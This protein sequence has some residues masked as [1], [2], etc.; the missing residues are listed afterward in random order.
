MTKL[1]IQIPCYNEAETL[2]ITLSALPREIPG[3]SCVEWLVIDDGSTDKTLAVAKDFGVDRIVRLNHNQG[4]AKAFMAGIEACLIAGADII[5]NTDAD[6]QY[7]ADDIPKLIAPILL[8]R[9]EIVIGTRPIYKIKHFS[10]TKKV[11]QKL[12][13]WVVRLASNTNIPDAPSGFR[14]ISRAAALQLNVFNEYTYTL[15]TIIQAGQKGIPMTAV[16]IRTNKYLRPSR[17]VK[18][19][20]TYIQR[21]LFTILRIFMTYQPLKFFTILGSIPFSLGTLLGI[22]W[23]IFFLD[24]TTRTRIPSLILAAILIIT[25]VQ[26]WL[27]GLV[28]D[29]LAVNRKVLEEI[30]LRLRRADIEGSRESGVGSRGE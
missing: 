9:A 13:S 3:I 15:E 5:V 2:G 29:L 14:A 4:L 28:A 30:Q 26:L 7:C 11:L 18:N 25:G 1:I 17:L 20:P 8:G 6:N 27:F 16:P 22:R 12:G 23:L 24:G 19:I 21:S 10:P